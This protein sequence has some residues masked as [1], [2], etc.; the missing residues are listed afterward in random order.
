MYRIGCMM[1]SVAGLMMGASLAWGQATVELARDGKA[2][3]VIVTPPGSMQWEGDQDGGRVSLD[4][5]GNP[6]ANLTIQD[7]EAEQAR[8]L[9]RD[10][11]RDLAKYLGQMAGAE[12]E[13]VESLP[14]GDK[15]TPIY[16]GPA[17]QAV[18]G[19]VGISKAD[20]GFRVVADPKK[21][22]GLYGES[23]VGT[24]YAIYELLHRLGCR[25]YMPS[26]MGEVIPRQPTPAVAVMDEKRAPATEGR[27]FWGRTTDPDFSRRNRMNGS[28]VSSGHAIPLNLKF[29]DPEVADEYAKQFLARL[30]KQYVRSISISPH[31][32]VMPTEDPEGRKF[33][34]E[35]RVWDPAAGRWS[36]TDRLM[37]F[38]NRV[39]EQVGKK[40]PDVRFGMLAYVNFNSPPAREPVHPNVVPVLA[41]IDFNR[42]HP[43][44]WPNHPN[45]YWLR[46]I[47]TGWGA[48]AK[49]LG[50]YYYGMNLAELTAPC[51]FITKWGTDLKILLD[52][53]MTYWM[54]E[55]MGCWASMLP[56]Y[57]L[58]VRMTFN[59]DEQPDDILSDLWPRFYGP[60]AGPM[61]QYWRGIDQAW[62]QAEE[63]SGC[64]FGYLR[65]F[66]P[67]VMQ[68]ARANLDRALAA[69]AAGSAERERIEFVNAN[70]S[71][72]E[73]L[74]KTRRDFAAARLAN[75]NADLEQ[76]RK[77]L[78]QR[79][80][81]YA[82]QKG[83][84]GEPW[85]PSGVKG[86]MAEQYINDY[87]GFSYAD[88][89]RMEAEYARH[90]EPML[91]WKWKHN[92][93]AEADSLPWTAPDYDDADWPV[94]HVVR[95]TWSTLGHHNSMTDA[96]SGRSGRMAYRATQK[97][98]KPPAGKKVFLWIGATDGSAK[99]FV[100][101]KHV[102]FTV[103]E[104][105]GPYFRGTKAG[106]VIDAFRGY[107]R[108]GTFEI[109]SVL[110]AGENQFTILAERN[111]L[112][113]IGTGGLMGPVV[114]FLEK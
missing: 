43:M 110:K 66:T 24:S 69:C 114:L 74:M 54:P 8:R 76:W 77:T 47:V 111:W 82:D 29:W 3:A 55:T 71:L 16:I 96:S 44:T 60:A 107:C 1:A 26:S 25:W 97:L 72:F 19:P 35:P 102:P 6:P 59:A 86:G 62:I 57:Y 95:D 12:F 42:H 40:Y 2:R 23:G 48:K 61:E 65:I 30:D 106:D 51:P 85:S 39:A 15:R 56:G 28:N 67:E 10:S 11:V 9:Q 108:P 70:F 79:I 22:L 31:D 103:P 93:D 75:L 109:T 45:E 33:D 13:I 64:L 5:W 80:E 78:H 112:N 52:N 73:L 92:P 88:A 83:F 50:V 17:A 41:P 21:G 49:R 104:D 4:R 37:M 105:A 20:Q 58:S 53:H 94:T 27:G 84:R 36:T 68:A 7:V 90:G 34:P 32:G 101:G 100:N 81:Q 87:V 99:L 63:H 91:E 46:D 98:E 89:S 113:E 18:F 38:A 14:A